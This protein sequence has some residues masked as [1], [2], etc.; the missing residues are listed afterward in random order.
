MAHPLTDM[1]SRLAESLRRKILLWE[2][3]PGHRLLEQEVSDEHGVSRVP[4][5]EALLTLAADGFV[6][7]LPRRGF[8]VRQLDIRQAQELYDL[9]LAIE[10][11]V[12]ERLAEQGGRPE[13]FTALFDAWDPESCAGTTSAEEFALIDRRF[14]E[15]LAGWVG[16]KTLVDQLRVMND[17][18]HIFRLIEFRNLDEIQ[19]TCI[20]HRGILEAI[21]AGD[22]AAARAALRENIE[23]AREKVAMLIKE[24]LA[25]SYLRQS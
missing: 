3:P 20:Q 21:A 8:R 15:T 18:I 23:Q 19:V 14:H 17:R 2:Y 4:T 5:R 12:V 13:G 24:A 9:R 22:A 10:L 16:N 7:R 1:G 25:R 11:F 6:D